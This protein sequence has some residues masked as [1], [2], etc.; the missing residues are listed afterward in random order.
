MAVKIVRVF[1]DRTKMV[2]ELAKWH[3]ALEGVSGYLESESDYDE[4]RLSTDG[5]RT[6]TLE[7]GISNQL[8]ETC[9][10]IQT[11]E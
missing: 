2:D 10:D 6:I 5:I 7:I 11:T 3:R 1:G 4:I 8:T 9:L